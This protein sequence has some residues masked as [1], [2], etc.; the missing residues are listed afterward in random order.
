MRTRDLEL[1]EAF[2]RIFGDRSGDDVGREPKGFEAP[3]EELTAPPAS[4][5]SVFGDGLLEHYADG[6]EAQS[7]S[8]A[9]IARDL[10]ALLVELGDDLET[11]SHRR[12]DRIG[13]VYPIV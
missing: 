8:K 6:I 5:E 7:P 3:R 13:L 4:L 2:T 1:M 11:D 9:A 12:A 10:Q